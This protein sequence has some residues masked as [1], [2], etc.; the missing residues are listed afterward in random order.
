VSRILYRAA[1]PVTL[2]G[3]GP[4]APAGLEAA[5]AIA[6]EAVA[7]DGGGNLRLPGGRRF[8]AVIGDLDSLADPEAMRR[9][10]IPVH[11]LAEQETT[12][13]EKCLYSV[14]APLYLGIGFVGGRIDHDLAAM[15]A[16]VR[17]RDKR[18]ILIGPEDICFHC[19]EIL[20]L[21]LARGTRISLFPMARARGVVS[22][23]LRWPVD[24]L[25]LEPDG[26]IGT[27]NEALGG[28]VRIG[29]DAPG[30]LVILPRALLPAIARP[31]AIGGGRAC[32]SD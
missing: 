24:A 21:D 9:A 6:P 13:F 29:F 5:L 18:V 25:D 7:A 3:G 23:G 16:L 17:Y 31:A 19:P 28:R 11:H 12:D 26:R 27:S 10:G 8:G 14:E 1:G 30:I 32:R 22:E 15:N 20:D 2:V 4:V